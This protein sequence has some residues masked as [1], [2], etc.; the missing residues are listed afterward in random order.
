VRRPTAGG[1]G[2][3]YPRRDERVLVLGSRPLYIGEVEA[4]QVFRISVLQFLGQNE[5][6]MLLK[7]K[8][9]MKNSSKLGCR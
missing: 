9:L 1:L 3:P 2:A 4:R 8:G 7:T 6:T 5:A